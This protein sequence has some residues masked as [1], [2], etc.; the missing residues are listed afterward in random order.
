[1]TFQ[2]LKNEDYSTRAYL[3]F[4][5]MLATQ[6]KLPIDIV[7]VD[8]ADQTSIFVIL[9]ENSKGT[10]NSKRIRLSTADAVF[11][12]SYLSKDFPSVDYRHLDRTKTKGA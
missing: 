9:L 1:M 8:N 12:T 11:F 10:V 5:S 4:S 6:G 2:E 3:Y 7:R